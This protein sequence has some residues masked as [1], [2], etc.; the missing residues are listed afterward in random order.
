MSKQSEEKRTYWRE[1]LER[2]RES[3]LSVRQ[4]CREH[5]LSEASF[6]SWKR[7]I[8]GHDR[9]DAASSENGDRKQ[10]ARKQVAKQAEDV[11]VFIPVRVSAAAGS[12][13]EV[14]HPRGHVLR[15]PAAFDAGALRQVLGVLD[16]Q[17]DE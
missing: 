7:K 2:Q 5:Q 4:F 13:L 17:G 11:A 6:H 10:P 9:D 8:A 14:V 15:V 1:V 12:V 16:Q 3:G